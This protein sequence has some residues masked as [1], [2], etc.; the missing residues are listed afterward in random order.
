[1]KDADFS[2]KTGTLEVDFTKDCDGSSDEG[3]VVFYGW[4]ID[5]I[6]AGFEAGFSE[7]KSYLVIRDADSKFV[8]VSF[9]HHYLRICFKNR[10]TLTRRGVY[11]S[12]GKEITDGTFWNNLG[13]R[14]A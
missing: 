6:S 14:D 13:R 2:I 1:M 10:V 8:F 7:D 4:T 11:D 9:F 5:S 3:S 12:E